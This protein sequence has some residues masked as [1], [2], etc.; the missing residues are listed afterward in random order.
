LC[1]GRRLRVSLR[2]PTSKLRF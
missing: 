2:T 1:C